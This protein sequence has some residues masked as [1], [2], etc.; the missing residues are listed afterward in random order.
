[1]STQEPE[2]KRQNIFRSQKS[3]NFGKYTL[4]I[5]RETD[6]GYRESSLVLSKQELPNI[7]KE[8][9]FKNAIVRIS[10]QSDTEFFTGDTIC[11]AIIYRIL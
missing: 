3:T 1:M 4:W 8:P 5:I 2:D 10:Q 9:Q 7:L 11:R 6:D